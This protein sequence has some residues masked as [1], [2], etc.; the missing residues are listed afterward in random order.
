[1]C[2]NHICRQGFGSEALPL[3]KREI[4]LMSK[5]CILRSKRF[6]KGDQYY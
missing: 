3:L 6:Y 5:V 1:M 2:T 4:V